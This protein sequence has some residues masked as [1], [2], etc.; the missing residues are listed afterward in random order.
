MTVERA[1]QLLDAVREDGAFLVRYSTN[2]QSVFVISW[3][4]DG[5]NIHSRL[6]S[7]GRVFFVNQVRVHAL[8]PHHQLL[9]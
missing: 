9:T 6:K 4:A 2:D 1:G 8:T 5:R 3:R 7:E